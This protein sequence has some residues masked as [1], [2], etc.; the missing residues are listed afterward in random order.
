MA[1]FLT[2]LMAW[3][4]GDR[5]RH[6]DSVMHDRTRSGRGHPQLKGLGQNIAARYPNTHCQFTVNRDG[7]L[8]SRRRVYKI[9]VE[10][11]GEPHCLLQPTC[12]KLLSGV[13]DIIGRMPAIATLRR[14]VPMLLHG[15][16]KVHPFEQGN[17]G[18]GFCPLWCLSLN[19]F[20]LQLQT[21]P[22]PAQITSS[23]SSIIKS[24]R[25]IRSGRLSWMH[26]HA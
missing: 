10:K 16:G 6:R 5:D 22:M 8:R 4:P 2:A 19:G 26:P 9:A 11:T 18:E 14:L 20:R 13:P 15:L 21:K 12:W 25:P 17:K 7:C 24:M 3:Q 23:V 1:T